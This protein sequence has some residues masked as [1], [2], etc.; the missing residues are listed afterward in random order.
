MG[1]DLKKKLNLQV[2]G[3]M[4]SSRIK[5]LK[6]LKP[7]LEQETIKTRE[8]NWEKEIKNYDP[9]IIVIGQAHIPGVEAICKRLKYKSRVTYRETR[10]IENKGRKKRRKAMHYNHT[11]KKWRK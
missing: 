4:L 5:Q 2:L 9:D 1:F 3:G 7:E 6:T 8:T 10:G 11:T